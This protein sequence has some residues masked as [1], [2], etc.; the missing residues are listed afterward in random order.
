MRFL[1]PCLLALT[2]LLFGQL[3]AS[4]AAGGDYVALGDS[5][6][7]GV[8]AG[9]YE[10]GSGACR[11]SR[12]AYP[13]LVAKALAPSAFHFP[14]CSGAS[15]VDVLNQQL[16]AL[17]ERTSLV[18]ITVGGNDLDFTDVMTTCVLS[19]DSGCKRRADRA[20]AFVRDELP[21]RLDRAYAAILAKAPN[22]RLLVLGYPRLFEAKSCSGGLSAAKRAALNAGADLLADTTAARAKAAGARYVDVRDRFAGHGICGSPSWVNPLVSPTTDSFHANKLG[23]AQGYTPAVLESGLAGT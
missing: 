19:G 12:H 16:G 13:Q 23:H 22:A 8:G 7:S 3:P 20:A 6:A 15:T 9:G 2:A 4:A 5:Y 11:R 14:A 21:A 1:L 18:T 10:R 17:G